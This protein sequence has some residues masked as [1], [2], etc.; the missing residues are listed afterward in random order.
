MGGHCIPVDPHYLL[1]PLAATDVRAAITEQ[2]MTAIEQ[3]PATVAARALAILDER[4]IESAS[5]TVL[6]A[7]MAYKAGVADARE[8][9]GVAIADYL[10]RMGIGEVAYHDPLV[11]SVRLPSGRTLLSLSRPDPELF[12]LVVIATLPEAA[13]CTWLANSGHVLDATYRVA[14]GRRRHLV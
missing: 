2:A 5:A 6:I 11:P 8:S 7:G 14:L 3:R 12:D 4:G 9:P 1:A 10:E 13:E